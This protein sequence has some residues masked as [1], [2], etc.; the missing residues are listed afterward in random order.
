M[1]T[2]TNNNLDSV[3]IYIWQCCNSTVKLFKE[4]IRN[5]RRMIYPT[6]KHKSVKLELIIIRNQQR[7]SNGNAINWWSDN[8]VMRLA[9]RRREVQPQFAQS[10][11]LIDGLIQRIQ[12][13]TVI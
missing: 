9:I 3:I 10:D 13:T 1:I 11:G 8:A 2:V 4:N 6:V 12:W 5:F 7:C